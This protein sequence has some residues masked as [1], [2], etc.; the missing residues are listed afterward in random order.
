[1][2]FG[3]AV[4][5]STDPPMPQPAALC[6]QYDLRTTNREIRSSCRGHRPHPGV[7]GRAHAFAEVKH[8]RWTDRQTDRRH[9]DAKSPSYCMQYD[10]RKTTTNREIRTSCRGTDLIREL[11]AERMHS[12]KYSTTDGETD[13]CTDDIMMP[14]AHHTVC[15]YKHS[16]I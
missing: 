9:C 10:L 7:E 13:G 6:M 14:R 11:K 12:L 4:S 8:W 5:S 16:D 3:P 1:M 15:Y 2:D